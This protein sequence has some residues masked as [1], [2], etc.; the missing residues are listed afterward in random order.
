MYYQIHW[1]KL[2]VV[3]YLNNKIMNF[4]KIFKI[5]SA[6]FLLIILSGAVNAFAAVGGVD[7]PAGKP[8]NSAGIQAN[9]ISDSNSSIFGSSVVT[10]GKGTSGP[11]KNIQDVGR[12]IIDFIVRTIIPLTVALALLIFL[13]GVLLY[14]KNSEDVKKREEGRQFMLFGIIGLAVMVSVWGLVQI[15]TNTLGVPLT[16]PSLNQLNR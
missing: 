16:L 7:I 12:A 3:V 2:R 6:T 14:I 10:G 5:I 8:K 1:E 13:W 11:F 4:G 15:L 9:S